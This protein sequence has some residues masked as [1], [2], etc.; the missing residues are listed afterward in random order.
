MLADL[1]LRI[2][3][4]IYDSVFKHLMEN[5]EIARGLIE[6]LLGV[7]ILDLTPQP[8]ELTDRQAAGVGDAQALMRVFRIDFSATIKQADGRQHK[9]LI[10]LQKAGKCEAVSRFRNYLSRHYAARAS[11][12]RSSGPSVAGFRSASA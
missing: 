3:N 6:R 2:A 10:D 8:I 7:E 9:V 11:G 4:P 12:R 5:L 1:P